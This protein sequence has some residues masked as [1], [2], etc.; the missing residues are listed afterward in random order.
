MYGLGRMSDRA[1]FKRLKKDLEYQKIFQELTD[2]KGQWEGN[3]KNP[4]AKIARGY[5]I[6]KP[7]VWFYF[8][9]LV[10]TPTKHVCTMRLNKAILI[11]AILKGYKINFGKIINKSILEYQ[12]NNFFGH[13]PHPS[14]ITHLCKKGGV[15]F[16]K[17]EEEKCPS[18][19]SLTLNTITKT[20][21][22]KE[23]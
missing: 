4:Y 10:L 2:G 5:L 16:D 11:C 20:P 19:P 15:T 8:L 13:I 7:K 17:E 6:K 12:S 23:K 3:K 14:I 9:R 21:A 18:N 1:K 22:N